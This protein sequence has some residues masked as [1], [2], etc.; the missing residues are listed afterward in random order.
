MIPGDG[1]LLG[2]AAAG[3]RAAT[4]GL[5]LAVKAAFDA[6]DTVEDLLSS[7]DEEDPRELTSNYVPEDKPPTPS[8]PPTRSGSE[9]P[10]HYS[11]PSSMHHGKTHGE[12]GPTRK[13]APNKGSHLIDHNYWS[14]LE[15]PPEPGLG[16]VNGVGNE[17]NR[18]DPPYDG[19]PKSGGGS[20]SKIK[21]KTKGRSNNKN[22]S[23][24]R[25][26]NRAQ[27]I[28]ACQHVTRDR[29]PKKDKCT[30]E[31]FCPPTLTLTP[32][33][34]LKPKPKP[35]PIQKLVSS[36]SCPAKPTSLCSLPTKI[37]C[38]PHPQVPQAPSRTPVVPLIAT[39]SSLPTKITAQ[40]ALDFPSGQTEQNV[41]PKQG[42]PT[43]M[44][45][46]L[47]GVNNTNNVTLSPGGRATITTPKY[48]HQ[49]DS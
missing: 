25:S 35:K 27:E 10:P 2:G 41:Y 38:G 16:E 8:T 14:E 18:V 5:E 34:K 32:T 29:C 3:A 17:L 23:K 46:D 44:A 39:S 36:N 1:L 42:L 24:S 43:T 20:K 30:Y 4:S 15:N 37:T 12:E 11:P 26:K 28:M 21:T 40:Q 48:P 49:N 9:Y 22:K 31:H 33:S 19:L 45:N 13:P 47:G 7:E 6:A